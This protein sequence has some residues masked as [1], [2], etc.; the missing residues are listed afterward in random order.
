MKTAPIKLKT[1]IVQKRLNEYNIIP[2]N[3]IQRRMDYFYAPY[4]RTLAFNKHMSF[5]EGQRREGEGP[6]EGKNYFKYLS[7]F[8]L[9]EDK[10]TF[11]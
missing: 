1:S 6:E 9:H 5:D 8:I 4:N 7:N 11:R 3:D 10:D 2:E